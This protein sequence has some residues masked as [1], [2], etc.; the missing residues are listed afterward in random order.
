[1]G[2][3]PSSKPAYKLTEAMK[4]LKALVIGM[5]LLIVLG[6]GLVG[7]GLYR[8]SH[9]MPAPIPIARTAAPGYFATELPVPAGER[10]EQ[11]VTAG[12]RIILRFT[13]SGDERILVIDPHNGQITG[14]ISLVPQ[15][16]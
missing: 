9:Q 10:L 6:L 1:M 14:S 11:M 8:N 2:V 4:A 15:T 13:G 16:H 12:D 3:V 7:F 5:G